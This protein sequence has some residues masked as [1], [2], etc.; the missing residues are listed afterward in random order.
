MYSVDELKN[1]AAICRYDTMKAINT[2]RSG[3]PGGCL[4]ATEILVT[5]YFY[6]MEIDPKNPKWEDRDRFF[7]SKGHAAPMLSRSCCTSVFTTDCFRLRLTLRYLAAKAFLALWARTFPLR[8]DA[9]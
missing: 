6:T 8:W 9:P 4:S 5:L 2:V 1:M 3:H 7:L